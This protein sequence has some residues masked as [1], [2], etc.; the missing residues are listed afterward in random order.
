MKWIY[1]RL[2]QDPRVQ[3]IL[4]GSFTGLLSRGVTLLSSLITLPLTVRYL[5][6][7]EYGIWITISGSVAM[8]TVLDL[9]LANTLTNRIAEAVAQ[10]DEQL[11]QHY[12]AT[13]FWLTTAISLCLGCVLIVALQRVDWMKLFHLTSPQVASSAAQCVAI[14]CVAT[15]AGLPLNLVSRVLNGYQSAHIANYFAMITN[16]VSLAAIVCGISL[17]LSLVHLMLCYCTG[18]TAGLALLNIWFVVWRTPGL[19]PVPWQVRPR[20]MKRLFS[21]GSLF[22]VI[23]LCNIVVFNSDNLVIAHYLGPKQVTPYSVA[24]RLFTYATLLQQV[25]VPSMWPALSDAYH[26]GDAAWLRSTYRSLTHKTIM[27]VGALAICLA[28]GGRTIIRH[29]IGPAAVPDWSLMGLMAAWAILVAVTSNQATLL[30]AV[31]KLRV[32]TVTA[33]LAAIANLVFSIY[34]VQHMGA[35]GVILATIASFLLIMVG[36]QEVAV[37]RLLAGLPSHTPLSG[38]LRT[39]AP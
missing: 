36:P 13:A 11:A 2:S 9:G 12:Y 17:R 38:N 23:Q 7:E 21:E 15:L 18:L 28:L 29:W 35:R 34:L 30:T 27:F 3:G 4:H 6:A 19:R 39:S 8:L 16:L 32:E 10:D 24:W 33:V 25:L 20:Y 5:G 1:S 31:G 26:R 37:R 14:A 22:F